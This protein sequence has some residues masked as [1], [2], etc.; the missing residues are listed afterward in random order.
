M[1]AELAGVRQIVGFTGLRMAGFDAKDGTLLWDYPFRVPYE[2]TIVTPVVWKDLVIV[3][4]ENKPTVALRITS[5]AG[6]V[7]M[8]KAWESKDLRTSMATPVVFKDHLLGLDDSGELVCIDLSTGRTAW[9]KGTFG[10]YVTMVVAGEQILVLSDNGE[11]HV[12]EVTVKDL[13]VRATWR[14][15]PV[16]KTW[17]HLAVAGSRLYVKDRE[18]VICFELARGRK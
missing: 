15:S 11:L 13:T 16:G 17:A 9:R 14:V 8:A 6:R 5:Q 18:H 10:Q 7:S 1:L 3:C 12:L 2:Q 4:G